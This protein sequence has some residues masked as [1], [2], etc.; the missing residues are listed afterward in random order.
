MFRYFKRHI[1]LVTA[2]LMLGI[3]T[4][5]LTPISAI[6]EQRMIDLIISGDMVGFSDSLWIAGAVVIG[7]AF[8]YFFN[9]MAEKCFS[10][11]FGENLRSDLYDGIMRLSTTRFEECDTAVYMSCLLYTSPSPR[12]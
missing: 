10:A 4:Q 11:K 12:D 7:V 3:L 2:A 6:L 9:G 1:L 8:C 5:L